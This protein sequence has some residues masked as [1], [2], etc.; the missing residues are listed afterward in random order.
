M[1]NLST[2]TRDLPDEEAAVR[3]YNEL[4]NSKHSTSAQLEKDVGLL[5]D[6]LTLAAFS[7]LLA[8]T[9]LQHPNYLGWLK[10]ARKNS[11]V[12]RKEEV[13]EAL[14]RFG[15]THSTLETGV[16]LARFRRRELIRIYLKDIRNLGTIAEI[17]EE[18]SNL[19]D[20]IL[21]YALGVA[22]QD[23]DNRF[24]MPL[25]KDEKGRKVRAGFCIIALGKLGSKELNY[26]SDIDLLFLF[27]EEGSTAGQR[28]RGSV[29]NRE[30][31]VRL[32]ELV[33]K[34]VGAHTGEGPAYRVDTRL[35][36][37][38]R[39][40][41]LAISVAD[42][43][44]YY[45]KEAQ[46]WERQVLI[47][48]RASA[49]NSEL[50]DEFFFEVQNEVF[51]RDLSVSE[52]L[53]NVRLSKEKIDAEKAGSRGFDVKLGRGG[54]REIEFLAQA[55]Q[56]AYGGSDK[57]LRSP[58]TLISLARLADRRLINDSELTDLFEAYSFLRRLEHRLQMEH[59]IQTHILPDDPEKR[60]LISQRMGIQ[61]RKDFEDQLQLHSN[62]VHQVFVRIFGEQEFFTDV[63]EEHGLALDRR[64]REDRELGRMFSSMAKSETG[65]LTAGT[66]I[67]SLK[68]FSRISPVFS[69]ILTTNPQ[70][71]VSLPKTGDSFSNIDLKQ[72]FFAEVLKKS[73]FAERLSE[74][75]K[76][77]SRLICRIAA[78]DIY[79][80]IDLDTAKKEQ[81][82]L[83]EVSV[84]TCLH[85]AKDELSRYCDAEIHLFPLAVMGLG[86]LG[87]GGMDYGSDLDLV[88][89]Y[90]DQLPCPAPNYSSTEFYSKAAE[91]FTTALSSMTRDGSLYRVDLRLRPDGK[92]GAT[93]IGKMALN[94]YLVDRAAVWE[95]LAYVKLRGVAGE[96]GLEK[97][98]EEEARTTIHTAAAAV[99]REK[100]RIESRR[101][102]LRLE[103]ERAG[104]LKPNEIDIKYGEGGLQDVYFAIRFLQLRDNIPDRSDSRSTLDT[105][106]RLRD[107]ESLS[108]ENF[109]KLKHGYN[110]LRH[111]DHNLRLIAGRSNRIR[112]GDTETLDSIV[113]RM[114]IAS[115]TELLNELSTHRI[116]IR[117]SFDAILPNQQ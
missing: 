114:G 65:D 79:G 88:L 45:K 66:E 33:T 98:I 55:L 109:M 95:W 50:F 76:I 19:A 51:S 90:D 72:A 110:F 70:I 40:G 111:L 10:R 67:E 68:L 107:K 18:I 7:P 1:K 91:L 69:R 105:L 58:H 47:R 113:E 36:P 4:I 78:F 2:L 5:S 56:L 106:S 35:R 73:N 115:V 8:T 49:G 103:E 84:D 86:K 15:L 3:F 41:R 57:W 112:T 20:A 96:N 89:V 39:V 37:H 26:S 59:G 85:V 82:K 24:G 32:A 108:L 48:S 14:A 62:N 61:L 97:K 29:T 16:M 87:G 11:K 12:R 53:R 30:Y 117:E 102:R 38:G 9:L 42:A 17:T 101:I 75:R 77:R 54:I 43:V 100:L 27:S 92:N 21:E 6:I 13:L 34:L 23:L 22:L 116:S 64:K 104:R 93:V 46:I 44:K 94:D 74:M 71:A 63:E 80:E 52:A 25:T 28:G 31:F 60:S 99:E 83:A 81:T